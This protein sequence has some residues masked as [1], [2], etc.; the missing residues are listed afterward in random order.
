MVAEEF[1]GDKNFP[2]SHSRDFR[3]SWG[4][5]RAITISLLKAQDLRSGRTTSFHH[6]NTD[7]GFWPRKSMALGQAAEL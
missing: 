2:F 3:L 7:L 1:S 6:R 5:S 4:I